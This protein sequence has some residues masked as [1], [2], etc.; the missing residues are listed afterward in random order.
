MK[1]ATGIL[2]VIALVMGMC[3]AV[4]TVEIPS[5]L[6]RDIKLHKSSGNNPAI[7]GE[8]P[9]TGLPS[10]K[11]EYIPILCQIDNNLGAIPQWGISQADIMYELPIAGQ[12]LTRLTALF[13]DQYPEEAGPVRSG[14][15]MHAELREEWDAALIFYGRQE[16]PGSNMREILSKYGVTAKELAIDGHAQK[17]EPFM[18]R[19]RYH[20]APHNV[21]AH[22]REIRDMLA[23]SLNYTFPVRPFKFTDDKNYNGTPAQQFSMIHS[24]N[25]DT[26]STFI[27]DAEANGYERFT[28][29]GAYSDYLNPADSLIYNNVIIQRTRMT[30]NN[31]SVNPLLPD[32]V[33]SGAAD[34]FIAGQYIAGAWSRDSMDSRTV[35]YDQNGEE[36]NLQRGKT[37]IAIATEKTQL[38]IGDVTSSDNLY[39]E[40]RVDE[41][42]QSL[43]SD[44]ETAA[45]SAQAVNAVVT[46]ANEASAVGGENDTEAADQN[47]QVQSG[48]MATIK[49]SNK[50]PLNMRKSDSGKSEIITR[51]PY[52][53]TVEVLEKGDE[54]SKVKYDDAMGYVMTKYLDF[55]K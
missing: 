54:W 25:K 5:T 14:R 13:S 50:G 19:V 36:L 52:Q 20:A 3:S 44:D 46:Q 31:S 42:G 9:T 40:V 10:D 11:T 2:L 45:Q 4:A 8:S 37:W 12:G 17:Y 51:I 26:S 22:V 43:G 35:F 41:N 18:P 34:I 39:T 55:Q 23:S 48:N 28:V 38:V 24:G 1:K 30:F 47:T 6:T 21:S 7:P 32:I 49:T 15:V 27:Y 29:L 53:T 16:V 33:G